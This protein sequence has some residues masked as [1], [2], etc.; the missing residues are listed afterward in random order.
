MEQTLG[1]LS[2]DIRIW[3]DQSWYALRQS[4]Q[5]QLL[6]QWS[7]ND[8]S[9]KTLIHLHEIRYYWLQI[10]Q[11]KICESRKAEDSSPIV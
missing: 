10:L 11:Y 6:E 2:L 1:S 8:F 9:Y 4:L 5:M 3:Q 7:V